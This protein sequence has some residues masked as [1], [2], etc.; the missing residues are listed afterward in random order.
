MNNMTTHVTF[1]IS[2]SAIA[3]YQP[4]YSKPEDGHFLFTYR[5]RIENKSEYTVKLLSRHWIIKDSVGET[6]EVIGEGVVGQQPV[7]MPSDIYEYESACNLKSD[8]G[9]MEGL[10]IMERQID[11]T[12]F[13]VKIPAFSLTA[14]PRMN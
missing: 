11:K 9:L 3:T 13:E 1:V 6:R 4:Y 12:R 7:L 8:I 14:A 10:Y 5:I 2:V